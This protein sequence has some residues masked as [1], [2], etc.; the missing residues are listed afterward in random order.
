MIESSY[1][2]MYAPCMQ[3]CMHII[4]YQV[5]VL[6]CRIFN[7][8]NPVPMTSSL[9]MIHMTQSYNCKHFHIYITLYAT[10]MCSVR[11]RVCM[12]VRA[13]VC[14]CACVS[15]HTQYVCMYVLV[16][17]YLYTCICDIAYTYTNTCRQACSYICTYMH[18]HNYNP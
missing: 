8:D 5:Y 14:V 11:V 3:L 18:I 13:R 17:R 12:C 4:C 7:M 16:C 15:V 2:S 1:H 9:V 10:Y 6:V